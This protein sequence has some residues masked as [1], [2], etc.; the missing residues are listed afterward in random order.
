MDRV[1][2][3]KKDA[4]LFIGTNAMRSFA[5]G[6]SNVIFNLYMVHP[7]TGF[8]EDLEDGFRSPSRI[9]SLSIDDSPAGVIQIE[10]DRLTIQNGAEIIVS[11]FESGDAG[12]LII[13][14]N[15]I[16]LDTGGQLLA[17]VNG[18]EQ[19]NIH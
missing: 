13:D 12:N 14:A 8:S 2:L 7:D 5:F 16:Q 6:V 17:Q 18:G 4:R 10:G 1:R 19:G 9:S 15:L 11:S 3:F